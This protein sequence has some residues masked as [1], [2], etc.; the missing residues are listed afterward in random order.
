MCGRVQR[1]DG[2]NEVVVS[3]TFMYTEQE[4]T[5]NLKDLITILINND[6]CPE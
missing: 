3:G 4:R 5:T 1:A 6:Y 2:R